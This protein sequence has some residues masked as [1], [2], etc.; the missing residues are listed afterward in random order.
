MDIYKKLSTICV[1]FIST[2]S[3]KST[4]ELEKIDYG[5]QV[6]LINMFKLT[7][8]FLT[9]YFLGILSKTIIAV[10][11]FAIIRIFAS[12]VHASSNLK[13]TITN[14][15]LF[16]GNV[17]LSIQIILNKYII[18][19]IFILSLILI[20]I[21]APADTEDRPLLS[22]KL[23]KKLKMYSIIVTLL[24]GIISLNCNNHVFLNIII[25]SLL[26]EAF[27]ITPIAYY[28]FNRKYNNYKNI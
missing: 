19:T 1:K 14:M 28:I 2:N 18:I 26:E 4:E 22:V 7:I 21:Y 5:I 17:Y 9:S 11:S 16:I 23:R 6:I 3:V 8:L 20:I 27:L 13:C 15:I 25:F 10:I 24:L 12:G